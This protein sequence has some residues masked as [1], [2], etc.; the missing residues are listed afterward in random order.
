[1]TYDSL[2]ASHSTSLAALYTI[3]EPFSFAEASLDHKWI[4]FIKSEIT[5][6]E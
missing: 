3:F 5:A 4:D 1:M 6:L 2:S